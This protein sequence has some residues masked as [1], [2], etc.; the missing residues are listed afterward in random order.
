VVAVMIATPLMVLAVTAVNAQGWLLHLLPRYQALLQHLATTVLALK[1]KLPPG[2]GE[3]LPDGVAEIQAVLAD[4]L[5]GRA[6]SLTGL[7]REVMTVLIQVYASWIVGALLFFSKHVESAGPLTLALRVRG[8]TF[9]GAFEQIVLAQVWIAAFNAACTAVFLLVILPALDIH[10][11]FVRNLVVLTFVAGLI[12]IV[13]NL[14]CNSVLSLVGLSVSLSVG[15]ACL[16]FLVVIHKLEFF[17]NARLVGAR[18]RTASWEILL[19]LLLAEAALGLPGLIA[20]P[21]VYAYAKRELQ[22][23]GLV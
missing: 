18:T 9:L 11:P 14:I 2:L 7:G 22:A 10:L 19:A 15:A 13:G 17:I 20:G 12:P 6:A 21:L 16:V 1:D 23:L 4:Y 3:Q 5:R 8:Q